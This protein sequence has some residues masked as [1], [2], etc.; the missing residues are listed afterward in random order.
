VQFI[1]NPLSQRTLTMGSQT[2]LPLNRFVSV[3]VKS[4]LVLEAMATAAQ[5]G[6]QTN[7]LT[8]HL[9]REDPSIGRIQTV[10]TELVFGE[11]KPE[12]AADQLVRLL[13]PRR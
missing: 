9:N 13:E 3:P 2:V 4:S 6:R 11:T 7:E 12:T 8:A 10:L 5:Q 1:A